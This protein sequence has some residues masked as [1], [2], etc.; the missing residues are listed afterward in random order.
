MIIGEV[1]L[2]TTQRLQQRE[3]REQR[4]TSKSNP[5][6]SASTSQQVQPQFSPLFSSSSSAQDEGDGGGAS[7]FISD[8]YREV[9]RNDLVLKEVP[10]V[11]ERYGLS[12][13]ATAAIVTAA[14]I[15]AKLITPTD[16]RLVVDRHKVR[17]ARQVNRRYQL[18]VNTTSSLKALY[19]DGRKDR[20]KEYKDGRTRIIQEE[21]ISLVAEP[22][23]YYVGH[24]TPRNGTALAIANGITEYLTSQSISLDSLHA[25]GCDAAAV[26]VGYENGVIRVLENTL[27]RPLQW[28]PCLYHLNELPLRALIVKVDGRTTGPNAYAGKI[29]SK[30]KDCE[31]LP[32][33]PFLSHQFQLSV[34]NTQ[35]L[36]DLKADQ[37]YFRSKKDYNTEQITLTNLKI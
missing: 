34:D 13:E 20:T 21:H 32:I 18:E 26:N 23:S 2:E 6:V 7:P 28:I 29:G 11:A 4:L 33:V 19:F 30:L 22:N 3:Q 27:G 35:F 9:E 36:N 12:D 1:D 15:D 16:R 5:S 17:R 24:F 25:V 8:I 14:Y 31:T 10:I 37:L